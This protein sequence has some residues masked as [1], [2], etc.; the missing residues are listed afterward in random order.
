METNAVSLETQALMSASVFLN[1]H[2]LLLLN[3]PLPVYRIVLH[4]GQHVDKILE[5]ELRA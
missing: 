4:A 2:L 1:G 3:A 5:D